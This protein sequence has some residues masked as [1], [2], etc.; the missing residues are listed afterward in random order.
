MRDAAK[1]NIIEAGYNTSCGKIDC[2]VRIDVKTDLDDFGVAI[3]SNGFV[4]WSDN[5]P[6]HPRNWTL[7]RKF[8][9][10]GVVATMEF[11]TYV[12]VDRRP[13][14]SPLTL[15]EQYRSEHHWCKS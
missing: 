15:H 4:R 5:S 11:F 6:D 10:I 2:D 13:G 9:D 14:A 12:H 1:N 8:Y 3:S 7:A